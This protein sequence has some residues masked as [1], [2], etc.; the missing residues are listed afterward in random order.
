[1]DGPGNGARLAGHIDQQQA[2]RLVNVTE[3]FKSPVLGHMDQQQAVRRV[4]DDAAV[5][6]LSVAARDQDLATVRRE[7]GEA[8]GHGGGKGR[9]RQAQLKGIPPLPPPPPPTTRRAAPAP[10]SAPPRAGG[11]LIHSSVRMA[12]QGRSWQ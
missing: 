2:V 9:R 8:R 7:V 3:E 12:A 11:T 5:E 10:Q 6:G 1:M 4:A